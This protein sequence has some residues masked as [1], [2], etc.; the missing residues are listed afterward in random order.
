MLISNIQKHSVIISGHSTSISMEKE[1]WNVLKDIAVEKSISLNTLITEID[2][3]R[4][5]GLSSAIR[6]FILRY[7][8]NK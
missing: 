5:G 4:Q 7:L 3:N 6:L 8:Q 2:N 1:F